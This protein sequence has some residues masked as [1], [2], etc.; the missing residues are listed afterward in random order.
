MSIFNIDEIQMKKTLSSFTLKEI[1]QQP[2]T[3]LKTLNQLK[4]SRQ[5]IQSFINKVIKCDD[6]DVILTG[7]G[8]SEFIG[9]AL[10]S[11]LSKELNYKVKS[12]GTTD[13]VATPENYLSKTKPTLLI[14]FGRSGNSPESIGAVE[15]ASVVCENLY[16]LFITCN[17]NGALSK[18]AE[19][20]D[21]CYAI[22]LTDETHD[23]SF[24]MTSS[25]SN[26]YLAA[27]LCFNLDRLDEKE[28]VLN[29]VCSST[30][31]FLDNN[32]EIAA[33]IIADYN[34]DRIV[35]LGSNTLKGISQESSLKMLELT[36]GKTV[37]V[38]DT[39]LGFRHGPK[40]IIDDSTL[41][42]VYVSNDDYTYKYELDL[43]KEISSQRKNNKLVVISDRYSEELNSLADYTVSYDINSNANNVE[44]GLAYITFAQTLAVLKSLS[45]NLTPDN[46]C[47]S[48]EVN[49][50]VKGVT[51]YPYTCK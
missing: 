21:N 43:I 17:K 39:P 18:M 26:M 48:G 25:F 49:R 51:L 40:S 12:Y 37:A 1:Y 33:K 46:P 41:T 36:A 50:V 2:K 3:W 29:K 20:L 19:E 11:H 24:A 23:Q 28:L 16:N 30:Q 35:Y 6:F 14:S 22:N 15:A 4:E 10:Y 27:Y 42:V 13:I 31:N 7:A 47:P 38:F 34:F 8:T 9:N 45:M 44:L 32:Y 5:A